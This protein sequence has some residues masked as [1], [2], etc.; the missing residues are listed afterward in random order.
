MNQAY[1]DHDS[2]TLFKTADALLQKFH[3]PMVNVK[4]ANGL[5][6]ESVEEEIQRRHQYA[7]ELFESNR[8]WPHQHTAKAAVT[9]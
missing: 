3:A 4:D 8:S 9:P 1:Q 2:R 7:E 6:L 5:V